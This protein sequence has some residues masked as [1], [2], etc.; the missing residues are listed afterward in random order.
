MARAAADTNRKKQHS[1]LNFSVGVPGPGRAFYANLTRDRPIASWPVDQSVMGILFDA[2]AITHFSV[3]LERY[4][5][6][7]SAILNN[8]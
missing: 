5:A 8:L 3:V 2:R 4:T 1:K 7:N 6:L